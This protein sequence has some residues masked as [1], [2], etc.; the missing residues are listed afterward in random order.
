MVIRASN[1]SF[2]LVTKNYYEEELKYQQVIDA[3]ARTAALSGR[4][5]IKEEEGKIVVTFP[6]DFMHKTIR[7]E[8]HLYFPA[9]EKKDLK[10]E[11]RTNN[12]RFLREIPGD[13]AGF[14]IVKLKWEADQI[15]YYY[16]ENIFL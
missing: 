16:E 15:T 11:F 4:I 5:N 9:D 3:S 12:L 10:E 13:A 1:E 8:F 7:G 14:Y 2:D 6:D